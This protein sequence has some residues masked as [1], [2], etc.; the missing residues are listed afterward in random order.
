MQYIMERADHDKNGCLLDMQHVF[1]GSFVHVSKLSC[2]ELRLNPL[3]HGVDADHSQEISNRIVI[4]HLCNMCGIKE[5]DSIS[6]LFVKTIGCP[7]IGKQAEIAHVSSV[8]ERNQIEK[9]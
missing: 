8:S 4:V 1:R 9:F 6:V 5:P 7:P 3:L 2:S